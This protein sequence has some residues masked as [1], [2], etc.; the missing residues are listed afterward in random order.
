M[1]ITNPFGNRLQ[2]SIRQSS[3]RLLREEEILNAGKQH[4]VVCRLLQR[5]VPGFYHGQVLH[6]RASNFA[7]VNDA[8][9]PP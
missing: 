3:V 8:L 4:I 7:T 1:Q 2:R 5:E 6:P 9:T